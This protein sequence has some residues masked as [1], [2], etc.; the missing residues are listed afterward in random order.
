MGITTSLTLLFIGRIVSGSIAAT[1]STC[2]AYIANVSPED[3]WPLNFSPMGAAFG[4]GSIIDPVIGGFLG[5]HGARHHNV[6]NLHA[7]Q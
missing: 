1:S 7:Y 5:E 4:M 2:N 6:L 3:K